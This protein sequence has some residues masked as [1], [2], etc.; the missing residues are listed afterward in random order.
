M[1]KTRQEMAFGNVNVKA[2]MSFGVLK[3]AHLA[4]FI[5]ILVCWF[6]I[7]ISVSGV[8]WHA[9]PLFDNFKL[10]LEPGARAEAAGPFFYFE[11]K[12][13]QRIWALPPLLS[14]TRDDSTD[15]A[16]F[17]FGYPIISYDRYGGQYR[18]QIFQLLSFAGGPIQQ[19]T[20]RNRFTL[21]PIYF[22]QRSSD[23]TESYTAIGPFYGHLKNRLLRDEIFYVLFPLYSETRK[24][25][26]LTY[27]YVYPFFHLRHGHGLQGWQFFPLTGYEHKEIT[28]STNGF[29]DIE[30]FGGH[31]KFFVLWPFFANQTI[32]IG[33]TNR[34]WQQ[35]FLPVY[36]L[37]R[38]ANRDVTTIGWPFFSFIEDR[39]KKYR[40]WE[41]PWPFIVIARGEG[42][43][44]TRFWPI[45]SRAHNAT[46]QDD[47]YLWPIYKRN[48]I[49]SDP[50]DRRRIRIL[51]FLYSDIVSKNTETGATLRRVDLWPFF[52][53]KREY[54]GN[55]RLQCLA[56]LEPYLP[57]S[58]KIERDYAPI[59]SFWRQEHNAKTGSASQS[60]LWNLYRRESSPDSK[61]Y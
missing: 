35:E 44:T 52:T 60:L 41:V 58:H 55:T 30:T 61:N 22:Q 2:S 53:Y 43:K 57:G 59:W 27:N 8:E 5:L 23:P 19:E 6:L 33:T 51:F 13:T 29:G 42:K 11:K 17:D 1:C 16:E 12:E 15:F 14:Y 25:D 32:G 50:L 37:S 34:T 54:N 26:V 48:R 38:S 46:I 47:F 20:A 49:H 39:E 3:V 18:F 24:R 36:S 9:G 21:F 28:T 7:S 56:L 40:E 31:K 4:H 45:F 10:T